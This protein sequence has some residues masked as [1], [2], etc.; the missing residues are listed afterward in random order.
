[1]ENQGTMGGLLKEA[2]LGMKYTLRYVEGVTGI[3]NGYI[4]HVESD[5]VKHPSAYTL[6]VLCE[7]YGVDMMGLIKSTLKN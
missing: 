5:K 1:M 4:S 3:S 7:L 2:R 6:Y